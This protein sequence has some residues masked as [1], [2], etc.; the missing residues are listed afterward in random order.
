[1]PNGA[2]W[3]L[4]PRHLMDLI[5]QK[6]SHVTCTGESSLQN[7][8]QLRLICKAWREACLYYSGPIP[9]M[10]TDH[11][12]LRTISRLLPGLCSLTL[13]SV[14]DIPGLIVLP[15]FSHLT[16]LSLSCYNNYSSRRS[17]LDLAL[18]PAGLITLEMYSISVLPISSQHIRCIGLTK[19]SFAQTTNTSKE[20]ALLLQRLPLLEVRLKI[21]LLFL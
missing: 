7:V 21:Q 19:L 13:E 3:Q 6:V 11:I 8:L 17:P 15:R 1:M 16:H 14:A 10:P 5:F 20:I 2:H 12:K 18:L 9:H 4:V